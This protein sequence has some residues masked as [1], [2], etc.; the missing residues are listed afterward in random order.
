MPVLGGRWEHEDYV[1][2]LIPVPVL[3]GEDKEGWWGP[4]AFIV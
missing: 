3:V 1:L 4:C 2:V